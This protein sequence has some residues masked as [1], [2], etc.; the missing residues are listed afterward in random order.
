MDDIAI[1][2]S[3]IEEHD[4]LFREVLKDNN[5]KLNTC[6]IQFC[7]KG[8]KLL[9]VT[10]N[11]VDITPSEIKKN[12]ALKFPTLTGVSDVRIFLCLSGWFRDFTRNYANETINLKDSLKGKG[13]DWKWIES[14][15]HE[16]DIKWIRKITDCRLWERILLRT[17]A[18]NIGIGAVLLQKDNKE[19]WVPV[20]WASKKFTPAEVEYGIS[21]KEMYAIFWAFKKFEHELE[22]EDSR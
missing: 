13:K 4:L 18:S 21:E 1:Y 17:D 7:E 15:K 11:G 19:E 22:K 16:E 3:S 2:S 14:F 9:W 20:Q 5:M 10:L 6:K 12:E 8:G